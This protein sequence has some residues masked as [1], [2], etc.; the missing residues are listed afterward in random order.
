MLAVRRPDL[1][2]FSASLESSGASVR[3]RYSTLCALR[4]LYRYAWEE[5]W[6]PDD[7]AAKVRLPTRMSHSTG[8]WVTADEARR[9]TVLAERDPDPRVAALF[10]LLL[11]TGLR[12]GE[13]LGADVPELEQY[14][15]ATT[16]RVT[17]KAAGGEIC[18]QRIRIPGR[19]LDAIRRMLGRRDD[20][21]LFLSVTGRRMDDDAANRLIKRLA[22][23]AGVPKA[24]T[25]HSL[26]RSFCTLSLDAGVPVR[27]VM[28][29]ANWRHADMVWYYDRERASVDRQ[30][31]DKLSKWLDQ[32]RCYACAQKEG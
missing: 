22:A 6:I 12:V 25:A 16:L 10:L 29:S 5:Q 18:R 3:G 8:T 1:E 9:M 23:N 11:L 31:G 14:G 7:P 21:P 19:A 26:R 15:E 17:R 30:A 27:D 28:A 20:G 32:G 2:E 4:G 13:A 24:I